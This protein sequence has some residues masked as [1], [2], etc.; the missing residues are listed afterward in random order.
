MNDN[1]PLRITDARLLAALRAVNPSLEDA[2]DAKLRLQQELVGA[3]ARER[4]LSAELGHYAVL[5]KAIALLKGIGLLLFIVVSAGLLCSLWYRADAG[6]LE[7]VVLA[8]ILGLLV[9]LDWIERRV[10]RWQLGRDLH[11]AFVRPGNG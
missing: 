10:G 11:Y 5:P 4:D 3:R 1:D 8:V 9:L 7:V 6:L 2:N